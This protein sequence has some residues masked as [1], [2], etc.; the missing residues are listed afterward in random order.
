MNFA[1][2]EDQEALRELG[3]KILADRA[4]HERLCEI[5]AGDEGVDLDLWHELAQANLVGA[6]LPSEYGGMDLG[7]FELC[8][9]L[10]EVGR[11]VAPVP[12][13]A[14]LALA[15]LPIAQFGSESQ[16]H[17]WLPSV[18]A[19]DTILSGAIEEPDA[20][21]PL[22][23]STSAERD[24]DGFRLFGSKIC[25]PAAHL[26]ARILVPAHTGNEGLGLF[27]VDPQ[28]QGVAVERQRATNREPVFTLKLEGAAVPAKDVLGDP[29]RGAELLEW[30]LERAVTGLCA[31][32]IGVADRALQMTAEYTRER[33][34][35]NRPIGSFQAVHQRAGDAYI[36]LEAMRL[37]TAQAAHQL[38]LGRSAPL[39]VSVAKV[40]ACDGGAFV[41]Y[42]AQHLHG[43]IGLDN[44]YPLHRSYL[45]ARHIELTLGSASRHIE[46]IGDILADTPAAAEV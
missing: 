3:R 6:C 17:A 21:D 7:V 14:T 5:E 12:L 24:G 36:Q 27:L 33:E 23:P 46:R 37:T 19:G 16:K 41:T 18:I 43:G 28:G 15:A 11:H 8:I 9:L 2:S 22:R 42:A 39:E 10:E 38:A 40:W 30:T 32:Q 25:V 31:M 45:W 44:D 26:A 29:E 13:W 1:Y 20:T 34:Q 4:T 35:F